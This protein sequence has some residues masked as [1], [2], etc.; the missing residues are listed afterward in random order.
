VL[1]GVI[2]QCQSAERRGRVSVVG[3]RVVGWRV[4]GWRVV[5]WRVVGWRVVG[6]LSVQSGEA[7]CPRRL[8]GADRPAG[9]ADPAR[10]LMMDP[11]IQPMNPQCGR[12]LVGQAPR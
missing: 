6:C 2:G 9:C 1:A 5:G 12:S 7:G 10:F 3:W 4:V 11:R 8:A